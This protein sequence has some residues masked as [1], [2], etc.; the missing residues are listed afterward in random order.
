MNNLLSELVKDEEYN[1]LIPNDY[2]NVKI[3]IIS[4]YWL[5]LMLKRKH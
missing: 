3:I 4:R 2:E 1:P 5:R